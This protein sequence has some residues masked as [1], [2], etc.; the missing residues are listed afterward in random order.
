MKTFKELS[1]SRTYQ[2]FSLMSGGFI[3]GV[4]ISLPSLFGIILGIV[5]L[6]LWW[7]NDDPLDKEPVE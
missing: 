1:H 6:L 5:C 2:K 4:G 3:L 7:P